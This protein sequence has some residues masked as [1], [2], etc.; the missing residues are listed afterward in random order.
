[1][2]CFLFTVDIDIAGPWITQATGELEFGV[3]T[4]YL[5]Y[6][7]DKTVGHSTNNNDT[8]D[9][10]PVLPGSLLK[11]NIRECWD[12]FQQHSNSLTAQVADRWLGS[13]EDTDD[14]AVAAFDFFWTLK[15][16]PETA[17]GVQN[18]NRP[19]NIRKHRIAIDDK[20][21][22]VKRGALQV[23]ELHNCSDAG[24]VSSFSGTIRAFMTDQEAQQFQR[25][26]Q[27]ALDYIPALGSLKGIGFGEIV[28]AN[29]TKDIIAPG[30]PSYAFPSSDQI[31]LTLNLDRP[32]CVAT[33]HLPNDNRFDSRE[34]IAGNVIKGAVLDQL[35]KRKVNKTVR[36]AVAKLGFSHALLE[37]PCANAGDSI[38]R[39]IT[40][41]FSLAH[42]SDDDVKD[43]CLQTG[44]VVKR[45]ADKSNAASFSPSWKSEQKQEVV[46]AFYD[47]S[48][49]QTEQVLTPPSRWLM[50]RTGT[51]TRR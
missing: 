8:A 28:K 50:T 16:T 15:Q 32:L 12:L 41:P 51:K 43:L 24:N 17:T 5:R 29:V 39:T 49:K 1:M 13:K 6:G 37:A 25:W 45:I 20:N 3:D 9:S 22:T 44:A 10:L 35:D 7:S 19:E 42:F 48:D 11:G 46:R 18:N 33:P 40:L 2:N 30:L 27:R 31:M 23:I 47:I 4:G 34:Y 21:G 26:L 38:G 14:R 36:A